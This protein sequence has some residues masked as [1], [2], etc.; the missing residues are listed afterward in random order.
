MICFRLYATMKQRLRSKCSLKQ[1]PSEGH[2]CYANILVNN[3]YY[4][5]FQTFRQSAFR[6][7][8][9]NT[10]YFT[11][12]QYDFQKDKPKT[13]SEIYSKGVKSS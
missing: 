9:E 13:I 7:R 4:S 1:I 8:N 10:E 3:T 12:I 2:G 6:K 11:Y 5:A